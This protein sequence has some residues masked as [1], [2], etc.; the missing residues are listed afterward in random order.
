MGDEIIIRR[1]EKKIKD[2]E[3][4]AYFIVFL[5]AIA[6]MGAFM[7]GIVSAKRLDTINRFREEACTYGYAE[8]KTENQGDG[9]A[10][11]EWRIHVDPDVTTE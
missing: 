8:W 6:L 1:L 10:I 3:H 9:A 5:L 4:I 11:F 2:T 7:V